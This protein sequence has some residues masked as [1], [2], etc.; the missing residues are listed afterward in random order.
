MGPKKIG[1]FMG[2]IFKAIE[3]LDKAG[4]NIFVLAHGEEEKSEGDGRTHVKMK[5]TGK[6]VGNQ[7]SSI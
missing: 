3:A 6:M 7:P 5:T 4:K 1:F 2:K